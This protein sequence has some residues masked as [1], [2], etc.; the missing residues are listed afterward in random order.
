[1]LDAM[2]ERANLDAHF[3]IEAC[4]ETHQQCEL[5][6]QSMARQRETMARIQE[7]QT[8]WMEKQAQKDAELHESV[9]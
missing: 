2:L 9:K 1:M 3:M 7:R 5:Q 4:H 8:T 6:R